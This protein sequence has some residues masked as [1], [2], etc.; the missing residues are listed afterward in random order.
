M[1]E[2]WLSSSLE[3]TKSMAG[4]QLPPPPHTHTHKTGSWYKIALKQFSYFTFEGSLATTYIPAHYISNFEAWPPSTIMCI[5][6]K[7]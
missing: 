4:I 5:T 3:K 1:H 2:T 6:K 7:F